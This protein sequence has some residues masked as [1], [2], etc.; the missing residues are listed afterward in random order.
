MG[1]LEKMMRQKIDM[2]EGKAHA[3]EPCSSV[4]NICQEVQVEYK[5]EMSLINF[6]RSLYYFL[7]R[8][9]TNAKKFSIHW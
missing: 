6:K 8:A 9:L 2:K 3:L 4:C 7:R 1:D 5:I